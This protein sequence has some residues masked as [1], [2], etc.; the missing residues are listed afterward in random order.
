MNSALVWHVAVAPAIYRG[1]NYGT[2]KW[3]E[4]ATRSHYEE[5]D[6]NS[7]LQNG[8]CHEANHKG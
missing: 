4:H 1:K 3:N 5:F 8:K 6:F 7:V 2:K